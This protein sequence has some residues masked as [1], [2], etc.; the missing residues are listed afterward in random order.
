MRLIRSLTRQSIRFSAAL[1]ITRKGR[2]NMALKSVRQRRMQAN[3][4]DI[5]T[6]EEENFV[7]MG[8]GFTDLNE[9]PGAQTSS[10]RYV[11]D[12]STSK[13]ITGYEWQAPYTADQIRSEEAIAYICEIGELL[14]TGADAETDY[15]IVDLD[16]KE[17]AENTYHARKFHVAIEV[18]SFGNEDGEMNC[19]GNLLGIGDVVEGT[20]NTSTK[21]FTAKGDT[22][23]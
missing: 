18:A 10:K 21:K 12:A 16:Q 3:Y 23:S 7:L 6:A 1:F 22:P 14:K 4:L 2:Y 11:N 15:V 8:T 20:F 19:E 9:E 17:S 5:G 13:G